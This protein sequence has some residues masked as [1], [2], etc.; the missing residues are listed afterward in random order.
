MFQYSW[1]LT[2]VLSNNASLVTGAI[3]TLLFLTP[4]GDRFVRMDSQCVDAEDESH[5]ADL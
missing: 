4:V 5:V 2:T 1:M 3:I